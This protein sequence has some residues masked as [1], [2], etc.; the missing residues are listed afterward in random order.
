[1]ILYDI[2]LLSDLFHLV[3]SCNARVLGLIPGLGRSPGGGHGSPLQYSFLENPHGQ[4]GLAGHNWATKCSTQD[5]LWVHP[6]LLQ[7]ASLFFFMVSNTPLYIHTTRSLSIHLLM[8][9]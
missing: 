7:M 4:K 5:N 3:S 8:D 1:M 9:I 6:M 2:C